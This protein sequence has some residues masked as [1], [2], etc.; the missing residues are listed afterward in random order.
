MK[1]FSF[2][3]PDLGEGIVEVELLKWDINIGDQ[4][5][6]DQPI[7]DVMTD[8]A[9]VE[10][11]SPVSGKVI[12]LACNVD[13]MVA[14]GAELVLFDVDDETDS[15]VKEAHTNIIKA[16]ELSAPIT[17]PSEPKPEKLVLTTPARLESTDEKHIESETGNRITRKKSADKNKALASPA[18]RRRAREMGIDLSLIAGSGSAGQVTREDIKRFSDATASTVNQNR[19]AIEHIKVRGLRRVIARKLELSKR[20]IPHFSYVEEIELNELEALRL[21]LNEKRHESQPKLT[22]L[23][24][25]MQAMTNAIDTYPDIN[26]TYDDEAGLIT[27][28]AGI[29][30]GIATQTDQGLKVPVMRHAEALNIWDKAKQICLLSEMARDNSI[31][32]QDLSGSTITITSLGKLGGLSSTPILNKP[33][34]AIIGINKAEDRVVARNGQMVIRRM[35]N[36]SS[37][38][39]H[40]IIDGY[41][42]AEFIQQIKSI[43]EHP[44]TLFMSE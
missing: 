37:S 21:H 29:H 18:V 44:V 36:I 41:V 30:V 5:E 2:K 3:M 26:S 9:N 42:A 8:K 23:P 24:F 25:I 20:T 6:K 33:E 13:E 40:R 7:A 12:T 32:T 27:R 15:G 28:Y 22:L 38:F 19:T 4:V 16:E 11:T 14:V 1:K 39:D 10:L 35:M 34:V 17:T 43:L 31:S